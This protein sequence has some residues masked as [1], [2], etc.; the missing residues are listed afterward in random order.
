MKYGVIIMGLIYKIVND[1][2][3][4]VYIGKTTRTIEIRWK[5]HIKDSNL[6]I[7]S[8][9]HNAINKYGIEHFHIELVEDN[10]PNEILNLRE[11]YWIDQY[12]SYYNGYNSTLGG[13]GANKFSPE[14]ILQLWNEGYTCSEI[15]NKLG[16]RYITASYILRDYGIGTEEKNIRSAQKRQK[17]NG[18]PIEQYTLDGQLVHIYESSKDVIA[19]GFDRN[20]VNRCCNHTAHSHK[21][22]LWRRIDDTMTIEELVEQNKNK[23][24]TPGRVRPY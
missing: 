13:E 5:D 10:I 23:F 16:C 9:F 12:D 21:K 24:K 11:R 17:I 1:V 4:K 7:V 8:K 2:N 14:E 3:D 22:Y 19:A 18:T 15:G 20:E 6:K